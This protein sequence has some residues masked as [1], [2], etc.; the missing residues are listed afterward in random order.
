M[1]EFCEEAQWVM[2]VML[3]QEFF[4]SVPGPQHGYWVL[5]DTQCLQNE[6]TGNLAM[7]IQLELQ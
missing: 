4:T 1:Q 7:V 6:S 3:M 2:Q 5:V